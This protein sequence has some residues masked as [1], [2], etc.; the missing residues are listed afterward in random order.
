MIKRLAVGFFV[1]ATGAFAADSLGLHP[2]VTVASKYMAHG[3]NINGDHASL[4]PSLQL[5]LQPSLQ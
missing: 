5:S 4:Q 3:F 2:D 1:L